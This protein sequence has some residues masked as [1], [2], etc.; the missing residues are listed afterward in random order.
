MTVVEALWEPEL[1]WMLLLPSEAP[2][3]RPL[4]FTAAGEDEDVHVAVGV[5]SWVLP[6]E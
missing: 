3:T 2:V 6:S 4:L 1:A 5:R